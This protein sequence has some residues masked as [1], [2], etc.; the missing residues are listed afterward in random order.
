M[1]KPFTVNINRYDPYKTYRFLVYFGTST[2]PV[3]AVSK[4]SALKRSSDRDRIQGGRQSDHPQRSGPH[5]IRADH[6]RAR[7]HR[8]YGFRQLGQC[9]A[10]A[11]QGLAQHFARQSA[12]GGAHRPAQRGGPA[13]LALLRPSLPGC[14]NIRRC[15][16]STPAPMRSRSSISSSR[17]RAGSRSS[18]LSRKN[19][20]RCSPSPS[21]AREWL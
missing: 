15:P 12:P 7:R 6:A 13:G 21:A 10:G 8:G 19:Y 18:F 5:Q 17:T 2:S 9:R 4:V 14:R 1:G 16:I 11:R 20:E 3:A